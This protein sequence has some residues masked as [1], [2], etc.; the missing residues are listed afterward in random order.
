MEGEGGGGERV[1]IQSQSDVGG[2]G[3]VCKAHGQVSQLVVTV[4]DPSVTPVSLE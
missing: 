4:T 1:T 3:Y 2:M